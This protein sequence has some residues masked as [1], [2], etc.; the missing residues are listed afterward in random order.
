M[1]G[2]WLTRI[3]LFLDIVGV[4]I[5]ACGVISMTEEKSKTLAATKWGGNPEL[6]KQFLQGKREGCIGVGI[7]VVGFLLQILGTFVQ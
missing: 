1:M 5:L 6:E 4:L 2:L 7:L 3:G